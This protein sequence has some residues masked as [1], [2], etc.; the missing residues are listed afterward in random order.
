MAHFEH[1]SISE[2]LKEID[3][4][5]FE[6]LFDFGTLPHLGSRYHLGIVIDFETLFILE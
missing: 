3:I 5:N 4:C 6:I 2:L 1:Y